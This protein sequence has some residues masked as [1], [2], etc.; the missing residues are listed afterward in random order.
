MIEKEKVKEKKNTI[1]ISLPPDYKERLD[2]VIKESGL[3]AADILRR[4]FD[5]YFNKWANGEYGYGKGKDG[6]LRRAK[7]E[8]KQ[9]REETIT[10]LRAMNDEELMLHLI[11]IGFTKPSSA[12]KDFFNP[13]KINFI[14][15]YG[16]IEIDQETKEPVYYHLKV[17][18]DGKTVFKSRIYSWDELV[19]KLI[20]EKFI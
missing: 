13:E 8:I 1:H 10:K 4:G 7:Q 18:G 12:E 3:A 19:K 14:D 15:H 6:K 9:S 11:K 17:D 5:L 16:W 20:K 2:D